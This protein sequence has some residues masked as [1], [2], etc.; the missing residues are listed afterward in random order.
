MATGEGEELEAF[1]TRLADA[2]MR[3]QWTSDAGRDEGKGGAWQGDLSEPAVRGEA[4]V[5]K[6]QDTEAFLDQSFEAGSETSVSADLV[7]LHKA[8]I[9]HHIRADDCCEPP[10][11]HSFGHRG[12]LPVFGL[13]GAI[14]RPGGEGVQETIQGLVRLFRKSVTAARMSVAG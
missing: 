1:D 6:W 5:G 8:C 2:H 9:R 11:H 7:P 4:H 12:V 10:L 3:G 13:D 14:L